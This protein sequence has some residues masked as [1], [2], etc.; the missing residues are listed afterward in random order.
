LYL[1]VL[2]NLKNNIC[3]MN[4]SWSYHATCILS[5]SYCS[6][7]SCTRSIIII[8][9]FTTRFS[10]CCCVLFNSYSIIYIANLFSR[11]KCSS[12]S[13][14]TSYLYRATISWECKLYWRNLYPSV[15]HIIWKLFVANTFKEAYELIICNSRRNYRC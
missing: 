4:A 11:T 2:T 14:R 12:Q 7:R 10:L 5:P 3:N 1:L 6:R 13:V 15:C 9:C 8:I